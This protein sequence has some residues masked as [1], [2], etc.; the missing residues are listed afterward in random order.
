[1]INNINLITP[2][3]N[4]ENEG[5]FY[6]ISIFKRKKDQTTD[7]ANHQSSRTIKTYCISSIEELNDKIDE[8]IGLCE[9]FKA[10]AYLWVNKKNH[11]DISLEMIS[12]IVKRVQSGQNKQQYVFD[13]V[14][15]NITTYE[16]RWIVDIDSKEPDYMLSILNF[17]NELK[18]DGNKIETII[19]TNNGYHIVTKKFNTQEFTQK[20]PE[21]DIHKNNGTILYYPNSLNN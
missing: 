20:Y 2:L 5:D 7:K 19:P 21:I 3:L 15:G 11:N 10:R 9:F 6:Y 14:V 18:P 17:I 4:F 16:K 13:S 1:M 12:Y 8:I